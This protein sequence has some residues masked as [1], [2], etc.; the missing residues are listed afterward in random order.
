MVVAGHAPVLGDGVDRFEVTI[1]IQIT[2]SGEFASLY[3]QNILADHLQPKSFVETLCGKVE[4]R[5]ARIV[6]QR[7]FDRPRPGLVVY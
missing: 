2:Q 6:G 4:D 7:M 3:E 5:I 1:L